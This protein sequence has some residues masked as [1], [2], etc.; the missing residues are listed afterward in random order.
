MKNFRPYS[1]VTENSRVLSDVHLA[2]QS[3]NYA[4]IPTV[5][6]L[7]DVKTR[8]AKNTENKSIDYVVQFSCRMWQTWLTK[9]QDDTGN[10]FFK[11][12]E[13]EHQFI[14]AIR[15]GQSEFIDKFGFVNLKTED[16]DVIQRIYNPAKEKVVSSK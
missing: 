9:E 3:L 11:L 6:R 2:I 12:F 10:S 13:I 7:S 14:E 8:S 15:K 5:Y 1:T 4:S 16:N